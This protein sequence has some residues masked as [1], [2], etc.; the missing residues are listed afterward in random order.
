MDARDY[1]HI[2]PPEIEGGKF[3]EKIYELQKQL[4]DGYVKI[5]GLPQYPI[6]VNTKSSQVLIKDFVGR[7][8]EELAEGYESMLLIDKIVVENVYFSYDYDDEDL[9]QVINHL[10]NVSEEF[11]DAMH[12]MV[13]LLIYVNIQPEDI[14]NY[15]AKAM[16]VETFEKFCK[17]D[18]EDVILMAMYYGRS[19][20]EE[21]D[22][23]RPMHPMNLLFT[24]NSVNSGKDNGNII[25]GVSCDLYQAA[26]N[27]NHIFYLD[28]KKTLWNVTYHLN[29]ARNC[30]KNKPWKQSQMMTDEIN[31]Q[32]EIVE[33]FIAL[34]G[35][36]SISGLSPETLYH[37]YF[38]KHEA[39][40][41]RQKSSY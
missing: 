40:V 33:G 16:T 24:Y 10:Q 15:I 12:F 13:E 41:F 19:K 36:F 17:E 7:V 28:F 22:L 27:Y 39:N 34:M 25:D 6:N 8:I 38:W 35:A 32:K 29:I 14:L 30:L 23:S 4:I 9:T 21:E 18:R 11:A 20:L 3:L 1:I 2:S 31:F 5:E 37:I 26:N